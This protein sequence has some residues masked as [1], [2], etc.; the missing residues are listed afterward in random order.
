MYDDSLSVTALQ[1]EAEILSRYLLGVAPAEEVTDRYLRASLE[2]LATHPCPED[3]AMMGYLRRHPW[4]LSLLDAACGI[5]RPEGLLRKKL[6]LMAALLET[7]CEHFDFF[8]PRPSWWPVLL[9]RLGA[10]GALSV[11]KLALGLL[12]YPIAKGGV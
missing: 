12:L 5:L 2:L 6:F 9:V 10:R 8:T 3:T 7:T 1:K 4:S 11:L